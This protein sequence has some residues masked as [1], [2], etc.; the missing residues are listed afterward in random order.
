M[1]MF[2]KYMPQISLGSGILVLLCL[3]LPI[4]SIRTTTGDYE[5]LGMFVAFGSNSTEFKF[6]MNFVLLLAFLLPIIAGLIHFFTKNHPKKLLFQ[7]ISVALFVVG[8]SLFFSSPA[9][10]QALTG[11]VF[12]D[13]AANL[14]TANYGFGAILAGVFSILTALTSVMTALVVE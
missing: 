6:Q 8:G 7:Y 14:Y 12:I 3:F 2:K 11:Q 5:F 4:I 10:F 13:N 9:L 1:E